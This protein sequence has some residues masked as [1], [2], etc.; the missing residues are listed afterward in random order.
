MM[1]A[2]IPHI[3]DIEHGGTQSMVWPLFFWPGMALGVSLVPGKNI[4]IPVLH[5]DGDA[6]YL[7]MNI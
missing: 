4:S 6:I 1:A 2:Y 3:P 5:R 7:W